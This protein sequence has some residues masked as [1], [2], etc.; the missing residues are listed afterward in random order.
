MKQ[1][2][3]CVTSIVLLFCEHPTLSKLTKSQTQKCA[4]K[5]E[6]GETNL[7]NKPM[8]SFDG[9]IIKP[10]IINLLTS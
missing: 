8:L 3:S 5:N 4:H 9:P 2:A 7:Q 1:V 6:I 10:V